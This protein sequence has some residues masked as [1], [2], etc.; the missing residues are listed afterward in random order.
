[1]ADH[2]TPRPTGTKDSH[3]DLILVLQQALE[4]CVRYQ[5]FAE[6]SRLAGDDELADFFTELAESDRDIAERSKKLLVARLT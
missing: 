3:Y 6:D 1:M 2:D 5:C 4:D